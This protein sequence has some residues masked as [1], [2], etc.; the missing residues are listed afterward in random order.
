MQCG[1]NTILQENI[2]NSVD[3]VHYKV[4]NGT[5]FVNCGIIGGSPRFISLNTNA[6]SE[7]IISA[8]IEYKDGTKLIGIQP[9]SVH[10]GENYYFSAINKKYSSISIEST[11]SSTFILGVN[12]VLGT[13]HLP[14]FK[15]LILMDLLIIIFLF[16]TTNR[17]VFRKLAPFLTNLKCNSSEMMSTLRGYKSGILGGLFLVVATYGYFLSNFTL[18]LDDEIKFAGPKDMGWIGYGRF[19]NYFLDKL[20]VNNRFTPFL[21]NFLAITALFV[22]SLILFYVFIG[23]VQKNKLGNFKLAIF[24][25]FFTSMPFVTGDYM[26]FTVYNLYLG[27][28]YI[29]TGIS[30]WLIS[31]KFTGNKAYRMILSTSLLTFAISIYQSFLGVFVA[32]TLISALFSYENI[33]FSVFKEIK[34]KLLTPL[35]VTS[36]AYSSYAVLNWYFQKTITH[37]YGYID[38]MIGWGNGHSIVSNINIVLKSIFHTIN[39]SETSINLII[40]PTFLLCA[41]C[42]APKLLSQPTFLSKAYLSI[43][44]ISLTLSPFLLEFL[45]GSQLPARSLEALPLVV[46]AFWLVILGN[47]PRIL[48]SLAVGIF[49]IFFLF[50]QIQGMNNLFYGDHLRFENDSD[51][52]REIMFDIQKLGY[53]YEK[54]QIVFQGSIKSMNSEYISN[55]NSGGVSFFSDSTQ[56]YRMNYFLYTLGFE[57]LVPTSEQSALAK[58]IAE[59]MPHWPALGSIADSHDLIVVN[60]PNS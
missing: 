13:N 50:L 11:N 21:T 34:A 17:R 24:I 2:K 46:A 37:A 26:A 36:A 30:Y 32:I 54:D 45:L 51:I 31:E 29:L 35:V 60:L 38:S 43:L 58:T 1:Y 49:A 23:K 4:Q 53:D 20:Q 47:I 55:I 52:A 25:G 28:G 5:Q 59:T 7:K 56:P 19:G 48:N 41:F 3:G 27:L 39:G 14:I 6:I 10:I 42:A 22:S 57:V 18:S 9:I 33:Q 12:S 40:L 15:H 8:N 16:T 44:F